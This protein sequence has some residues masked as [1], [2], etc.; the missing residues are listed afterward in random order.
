[1][2]DDLDR[3]LFEHRTGHTYTTRRLGGDLILVAQRAF[4][5]RQE[6]A[7][8]E[9][10]LKSWKSPGKATAYLNLPG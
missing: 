10:R 1:M 6:A 2:T 9:R 8:V 7:Q 3:R 5:T 4:A